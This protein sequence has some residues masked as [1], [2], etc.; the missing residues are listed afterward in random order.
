MKKLSLLLF[1]LALLATACQKTQ[2]SREATP[3]TPVIFEQSAD[4]EPITCEHCRH[5]IIDPSCCCTII[6]RQSN[7]NRACIDLCGTTSPLVPDD[8]RRDCR[9]DPDPRCDYPMGPIHEPGILMAVGQSHVYCAAI[10]YSHCITNCG[11]RPVVVE[12]RCGGAP[13]VFTINP[14]ICQSVS[15]NERCDVLPCP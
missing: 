4:C 9:M 1:C 15:L 3:E 12:V 7:E 8:C 13:R 5:A 14:G 2:E 10:N 11:Q 6:I